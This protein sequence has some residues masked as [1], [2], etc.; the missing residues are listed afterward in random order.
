MGKAEWIY[1]ESDIALLAVGSMV[2]TAEDV[3]NVLKEKGYEVSLVNARFVKPIDQ[4]AVKEACCCHRLIVT[5]E[6]NV[7]CGGYGE[8]VLDCMNRNNLHNAFLSIS[9]P[10]A[11]V[12]HGNVELLKEELEMDVKSV[13]RRIEAAL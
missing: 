9:I 7:A 10:D 8:K 3:R 13:V 6:E 1:H 2:K 12:E 11:Y 4:E 5:M